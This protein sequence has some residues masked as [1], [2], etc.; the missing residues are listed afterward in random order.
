MA[1]RTYVPLKFED[2]SEL[3]I[4]SPSRTTKVVHHP[5]PHNQ[6]SGSA[7][8]LRMTGQGSVSDPNSPKRSRDDGAQ[9]Q[10][11]R[12]IESFGTFSRDV[13]SYPQNVTSG[14][15]DVATTGGF[16]LSPSALST[17]PHHHH[18]RALWASPD[19]DNHRPAAPKSGPDQ[20][21]GVTAR[22]PPQSQ[23]AIEPTCMCAL[24]TR[25]PPRLDW[26]AIGATAAPAEDRPF[27]CQNCHEF[28]THRARE[29]S[30]MRHVPWIFPEMEADYVCFHCWTALTPAERDEYED[31]FL[32]KWGSRFGVPQRLDTDEYLKMMERRMR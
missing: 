1:R 14:Q 2:E 18:V 13:H 5:L 12:A 3:D 32:E 30:Q 23:P 24:G 7:E 31:L 19:G 17:G 25:P 15:D 26:A 8:L 21:S 28:Y 22:I 20:I 6:Q 10:P 16:P 4:K 11:E 9:F 29:C 27:L